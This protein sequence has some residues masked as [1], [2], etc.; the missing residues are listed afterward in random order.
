MFPIAQ[1]HLPLR[2]LIAVVLVLLATLNFARVA[3]EQ[4]TAL[5]T[6]VPS[7]GA[8][9][10]D[11]ESAVSSL[12]DRD[13]PAKFGEE[14]LLGTWEQDKFG[15]RRLTIL[16]DGK[17]KMLIEPAGAWSLAFGSKLEAEMFWSVEG[18]RIIYGMTSGVPAAKYEIAVKAWGDRWNELLTELTDKRLVVTADDG[19]VSIWQRV[20]E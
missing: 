18:D 17:A 14:R 9:N 8:L 1:P 4:S 5:P 11:D 19:T 13:T 15:R 20:A 3:R 2:V 7:E 12:D 6:V 10:D 16:P